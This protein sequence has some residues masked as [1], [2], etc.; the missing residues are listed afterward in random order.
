MGKVLERGFLWCLGYKMQSCALRV[1]TAMPKSL[2]VV[3]M[4]TGSVSWCSLELQFPEPAGKG[5]EATGREHDC[6]CLLLGG[7]QQEAA[8][9][10]F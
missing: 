8:F 2:Q 7:C 4:G 10:F 9:L 1:N 6:Q 5:G 3:D